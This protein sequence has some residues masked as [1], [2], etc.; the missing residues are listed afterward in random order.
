MS[1]KPVFGDKSS[2]DA[3]RRFMRSQLT[4]SLEVVRLK[5]LGRERAQADQDAWDAMRAAAHPE[6]IVPVTRKKRTRRARINTIAPSDYNGPFVTLYHNLDALVVNVDGNLRPDLIELISMAQEEAKEAD[7][8]V[9]SPLPPF[10]A[11]NL[12]I[13]PHGGG[14]FRFLLG[15]ADVTVKLRKH[16]RAGNMALAQVDLTSACLHRLGWLAAI[17][18]LEA[19]VAEWVVA[20]KLQPSEVD[21]AADTQGWQPTFDDFQNK[22]FVCPVNRPHLIPYEDG[23]L[24]YVRWGT[25]GRSGSRSGPAPIQGV[26]YDKTEDIRTHDKGWFVKLWAENPAY[27]ED[28]TVT[29]IEFRFRRE[30][31]KE[32]GI[33]TLPD[34]E[35]ALDAMW[36]E[37]LEWCRYCYP[38][39]EGGDSNRS[40][41]R[42]R[43]EWFMLKGL[44]WR[45]GDKTPLER[46]DQ[47][48][49]KLE[50]LLAVLGG[51]LT[52]VHALVLDSVPLDPGQV[53]ALIGPSL[54]KR[55]DARGEDYA[56][57]VRHRRLSMGGL[58]IA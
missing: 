55:W 37:A 18:A 2:I 13:K 45:G 57:K 28:E 50:R 47:A 35:W 41:L 7:D 26:V 36:G 29:R 46:I 49:P 38:P 22:A 14:T 15:N 34:L 51:C 20:P 8:I 3:A 9:L 43:E 30:W 58:A 25:G 12:S 52:S 1:R 27:R 44:V 39:E 11:E 19:W 6:T 24:G 40:R 56:D 21:L 17:V 16:D 53:L 48:R 54:Q 23:T 5:E 32:R 4:D 33:D 42:V 31:M 10:L